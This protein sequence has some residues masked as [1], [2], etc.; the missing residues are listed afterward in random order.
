MILPIRM[1]RL[2]IL[3]LLNTAMPRKIRDCRF[4]II[5]LPMT[6][7]TESLFSMR[8]TPEVL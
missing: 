1:V 6:V 3:N 4:L 2:E 8:I 7:I 5:P